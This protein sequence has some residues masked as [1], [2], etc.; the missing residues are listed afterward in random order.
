MVNRL[1]K[2]KS[3]VQREQQVLRNNARNLYLLNK[4]PSAAHQ[5]LAPLIEIDLDTEQHTVNKASTK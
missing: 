5:E 1:Q 4:H 2:L 3:L